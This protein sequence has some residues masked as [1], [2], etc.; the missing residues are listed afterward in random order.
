MAQVKLFDQVA[1]FVP[2]SDVISG[3][4]TAHF[5]STNAA[6]FQRILPIDSG[7]IHISAENFPPGS[8]AAFV[9]GA[10]QPALD[11]V[12]WLRNDMAAAAKESLQSADLDALN[13]LLYRSEPEEFDTTKSRG[14]VPSWSFHVTYLLSSNASIVTT[15]QALVS[16]PTVASPRLLPCLTTTCRSVTRSA[17][18]SALAIGCSASWAIA[19]SR[20]PCSRLF[21]PSSALCLAGRHT[22]AVFATF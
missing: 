16:C 18:T 12:H 22:I 14:Y 3:L 10:S 6:D 20:I 13:V 8:V 2:L 11:A 15:S 4:K 17:R 9:L 1:T 7:R 5:V 21:V 19:C